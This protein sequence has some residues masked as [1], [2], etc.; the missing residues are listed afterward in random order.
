MYEKGVSS[1]GESRGLGLYKA[2]EIIDVWLE[3][4]FL[5]GKYAERVDKLK[6][7]T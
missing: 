7:L 3:E 6:D 5:G 1:K 2:K 4:K